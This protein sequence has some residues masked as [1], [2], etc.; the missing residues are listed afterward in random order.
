[1][2]YN[3]K[4]FFVLYFSSPFYMFAIN[5][6]LSIFLNKYYPTLADADYSE[7]RAVF[8]PPFDLLSGRLAAFK[9]L[10]YPFADATAADAAVMVMVMIMSDPCAHKSFQTPVNNLKLNV[11]RI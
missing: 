2:T 7:R 11:R 3:A 4:R 1:M 5:I 10:H 8:T 6:I 9:A